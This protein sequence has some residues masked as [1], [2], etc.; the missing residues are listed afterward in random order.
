[1][2]GYLSVSIFLEPH[3]H[4]PSDLKCTQMKN[5]LTLQNKL[6]REKQALWEAE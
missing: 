3:Y 2:S 1:M 5:V 6:K 4:W